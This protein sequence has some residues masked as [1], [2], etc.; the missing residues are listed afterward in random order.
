MDPDAF[1]VPLNMETRFIDLYDTT[2]F[3]AGQ[4]REH[5]SLK[6]SVL[7]FEYKRTPCLR[8]PTYVKYCPTIAHIRTFYMLMIDI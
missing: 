5:F 7:G 8:A 4:F 1:W 3:K 6:A 2:I